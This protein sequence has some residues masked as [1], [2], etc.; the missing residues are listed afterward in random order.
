MSRGCLSVSLLCLLFREREPR[1]AVTLSIPLE[2]RLER[3]DEDFK[4]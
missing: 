2:G 4:A 1:S 3:V